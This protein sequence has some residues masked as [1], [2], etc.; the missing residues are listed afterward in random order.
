LLTSA[1]A[2]LDRDDGGLWAAALAYSELGLLA[3]AGD[4]PR[5]AALV[6]EGLRLHAAIGDRL[7]AIISLAA[8][9]QVLAAAG[10]PDAARLLG[11]VSALRVQCGPSLWVVAQPAHERAMTLAR[12]SLAERPVRGLADAASPPSVEAATAA[13]LSALAAVTGA[14]VSPA[15]TS[16]LPTAELSPRELD[17]LRLVMA[18]QTDQEVAATLGLKVRTVN[19]YVANARRKL[20]APSRAAAVAALLR[21]GLL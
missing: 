19:A 12:A 15:P 17:V 9:A 4:L 8:A 16:E 20:G 6:A 21:R 13:A 11:A 7:V 3:A 5:A 18:G 1:I 10:H 2:V 14:Q